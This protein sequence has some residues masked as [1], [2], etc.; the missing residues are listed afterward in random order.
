MLTIKSSQ[1]TNLRRSIPLRVCTSI[2]DYNRPKAIFQ[3]TMETILQGV[4]RI[5]V[6]IDGILVSGKTEEERLQNLEVLSRLQAVGVRLK[7]HKC[8]FILP[9]VEYLGRP[10]YLRERPTANYEKG[11]GNP[12]GPSSNQSV[13][14]EVLSRT[15]KLLQQTNLLSMLSPL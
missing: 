3:N 6:Y 5:S 15:N 12:V 11:S 4:P 9:S 2:I 13:T 10:L 7:H 1:T 8:Y 14:A